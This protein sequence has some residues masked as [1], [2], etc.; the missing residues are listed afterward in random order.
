MIRIGQANIYTARSNKR[1]ILIIRSPM[2]CISMFRVSPF[3]IIMSGRGVII[4]YRGGRGNGNR[5][6][7]GRIRGHNYSGTSS[8]ANRGLYNAI[9]TSVF[10]YSQK[11]A[12]DQIRSSWEKL[13]Q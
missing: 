1:N 4:P 8:A 7:R 10:D 12:A 6:G 13:V 2:A 5:V 11:S 9:G 3:Y